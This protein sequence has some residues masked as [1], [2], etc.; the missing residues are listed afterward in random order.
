M[1]WNTNC[2]HAVNVTGQSA[3]LKVDINGAMIEMVYDP[4]AAF[5]I[6]PLRLWQDLGRPALSSVPTLQAYTHIPIAT[7]GRV[8]VDVRAFGQQKQLD[9]I[10]V[11]TDDVCLFGLDWCQAFDL[12]LPPGVTI[13]NISAECFNANAELNK[14]LAEFSDVFCDSDLPG[15]LTGF[16]ASVHLKAGAQPRAYPARPVP[17]PLQTA[18]ADELDR[19]VHLDIL[20]PVE[21]TEMPIQWATP[22][23]PVI[24]ANGQV[25][26]CGDFKLTL[27]DN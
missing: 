6:F 14:L 10:V 3:V 4:G 24:K 20:E 1:N 8:T 7:R 13:R 27:T 2:I 16:E 12:K 21:P 23:V 19:L 15:T 17:L 25:R 18:V 5:T 26:I 9:A 11:D 22:T